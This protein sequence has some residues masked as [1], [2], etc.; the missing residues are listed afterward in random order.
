VSTLRTYLTLGRISNLPTVWSNTLAGAVLAGE[1]CGARG[2][3]ACAAAFSL[4]YTGGM[5]LNDAFDR[6]HDAREQPFRPIPSGKIS[7][8]AVFALGFAQLG[9]GALLVCLV[10]LRRHTL[11]PSMVGCAALAAAIVLY[12]VWHKKN[13]LSPVLMGLCR[14]FV[15]LTAGLALHGTISAAVLIGAFALFTY[16]NVLT[17]V[18]KRAGVPGRVVARFIAG[19]SIVDALCIALAGAPL[20]GLV[21]ALGFPLTLVGQRYVRG[22]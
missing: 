8:Q 5:F 6:K 19:I 11:L 9:L 18:A 10:A 2:I 16:L 7:A 3:V 22:T 15:Y 1:A 20:L 12:D 4:F 14:A 21:A 17:A 13:P